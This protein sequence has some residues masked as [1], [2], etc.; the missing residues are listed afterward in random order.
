MRR[1]HL[2]SARLASRKA[3]VRSSRPEAEALEGRVLLYST[4]GQ[5]TYSSR[6]TYSFMPDGTSIGGVPSALFATM[7]EVAA[8]GTWENQIEQAATIWEANAD[9]NLALVSDDG[10][11]SGANGDQQDDPNYGD[12]RIGA[13]PLPQGVLAETFLPPPTNGGTVAGDIVFNSTVAWQIGTGYDLETVAAHEIG[14]ALGLGES[15][16]SQAVM[17]GVYDGIKTALDADDIAGIQSLY[18]APQYDRFNNSGTHNSTFLTAVNLNTYLASG[19][20]MLSG[21]DHTVA[22][23]LQWYAVTVPAGNSGS[24]LVTLQSSNLSSLAPTLDIYNA[25][26]QQVA[27]AS[28]PNTYGGTVWTT[29]SVTA[30]QKYYIEVVSPYSYGRVGA[31]GLEVNFT[32]NSMPPIQPPNTLVAQQPNGAS[33]NAMNNAFSPTTTDITAPGGNGNGDGGPGVVWSVIGDIAGW[34]AT[35]TTSAAATTPNP[36]S[37]PTASAPTSQPSAVAGPIGTVP[38][39]SPAPIVVSPASGSQAAPLPA[40]ATSTTTGHRHHKKAAHHAVDATLSAW[41]GHR[42]RS[43]VG[44]KV[45][46]AL[47]GHDL[48]S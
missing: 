46:P 16:D 12:I 8:T 5:W 11:P 42:R 7:N 23:Q 33:G 6:I 47:H 20:I 3:R 40:P 30:G 25:S 10:E 44:G 32:S 9:L 48:V 43:H 41:T 2:T 26:L 14:H 27:T 28:L 17:Y 38:V 34:A 13:V 45:R 15:T 24:M 39:A 4:I 35:M 36:V 19:E 37:T 18:G 31:Y 22:T 1:L 29:T 21:L